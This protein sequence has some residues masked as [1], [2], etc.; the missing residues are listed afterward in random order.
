MLFRAKLRYSSFFSRPTFS[1]KKSQQSKLN[2]NQNNKHKQVNHPITLT[3]IFV[4][5]HIC[6]KKKIQINIICSLSDFI[7][8]QHL[9][10]D[11]ITLATAYAI[12]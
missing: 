1:V 6:I 4:V 5:C 2:V 8:V 11:F 12:L 9:T 3:V 10:N 7:I